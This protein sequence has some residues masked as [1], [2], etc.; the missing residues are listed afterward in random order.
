VN[1]IN[2]WA[3][4][5][6][7]AVVV[8]SILEMMSPGGKMQRIIHLVLGAFLLCTIIVPISASDLKLDV[9]DK[10]YFQKDGNKLELKEEVENQTQKLACENLKV[11]INKMMEKEN[12]ETD[13]IEIFMDTEETGRISINKVCVVLKDKSSEKIKRAEKILKEEIKSKEITVS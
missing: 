13:E 12:L 1:Q 10:K 7:L 4:I 5:L 9:D 8:C 6:C 3:F 2:Q 11:S